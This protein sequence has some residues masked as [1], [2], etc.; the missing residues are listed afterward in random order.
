MDVSERRQ[1]GQGG[2]VGVVSVVSN[3]L[4]A[5]VSEMV[6]L[7][8][9]GRWAD[10]LEMHDQMYDLFGTML[11]LETNPVPVKTALAMMNMVNENFRLP[12][13]VLED[14]KRQSL[15]KLLQS[16]NLI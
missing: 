9:S 1:V 4:P 3:I 13:D 8:L 11:S 5:K 15:E 14:G 10:A 7:A 16:H 6:R 12:L 2:A